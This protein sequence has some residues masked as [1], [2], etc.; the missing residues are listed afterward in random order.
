MQKTILREEVRQ[1]RLKHAGYNLILTLWNG[2]AVV[3]E[4]GFSFKELFRQ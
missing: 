1:P 3:A 2:P 4:N